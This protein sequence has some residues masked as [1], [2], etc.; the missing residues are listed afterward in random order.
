M[1]LWRR[2]FPEGRRGCEL[3]THRVFAMAS[4]LSLVERGACESQSEG[5]ADGPVGLGW[6]VKSLDGRALTPQPG[7]SQPLTLVGR[8]HLHRD[9]LAPLL[10]A[11]AAQNGGQGGGQGHDADDEGSDGQPARHPR[12]GPRVTLNG[13][14]GARLGVAN[15]RA[16]E[17][18]GGGDGDGG[19]VAGRLRVAGHHRDC[20][21][22]N[23][24]DNSVDVDDDEGLTSDTGWAGTHG[25]GICPQPGLVEQQPVAEW[26]DACVTP[27]GIVIEPQLTQVPQVIKDPHGKVL[28]LVV[29]QLNGH[30]VVDID[31]DIPRQ[32]SE[33]V[34]LQGDALQVG[35]HTEDIAIE[36][37]Q[38][39]GVEGQLP[40]PHK[41]IEGVRR[42]VADLVAAEDQ[43]LQL[44]EAAEN[45]VR[46]RSDVVVINPKL[47]QVVHGPKDPRRELPQRIPKERETVEVGQLH[48][49]ARGQLGDV[50]VGQIEL[51]E[52]TV[53]VEEA[54]GEHANLILLQG[55]LL[56]VPTSIKSAH[57]DVREPVLI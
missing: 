10:T 6:T 52:V 11:A 21:D 53:V 28:Q 54:R 22:R 17:P 29:L 39:I 38:C 13:L 24:R 18:S 34:V 16:D 47:S 57:G 41:P 4:W 56:E 33:A 43:D 23:S 8:L 15:C 2:T 46:Y 37:L 51:L 27:P 7:P 12:Q 25:K 26:K 9:C 50:V 35:Q 32:L 45:I 44:V 14:N 30:E 31:K 49:N 1:R 5:G 19:R 3:E 40:Q 42:D 55:Q 36:L 48:E 20:W